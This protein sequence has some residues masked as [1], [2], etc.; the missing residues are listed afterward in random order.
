[1]KLMRITISMFVTI[2]LGLL[3]ALNFVVAQVGQDKSGEA[4]AHY[5]KAL[6][7]Q[8]P[9]LNG[10]AESILAGDAT[11]LSKH[12]H[13]QVEITLLKER[14]DYARKQATFILKQFFTDYPPS[15]FSVVH[16]GNTGSI[17]YALGEYRSE[18]GSFDVNIFLKSEGDTYVIE[19]LRFERK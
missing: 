15:S 14:S 8:V 5:R 16:Q 2:S 9:V 11:A 17:M 18:A 6:S 3:L 1:M 10:I 4:I 7:M 12:F 13:D 19:R